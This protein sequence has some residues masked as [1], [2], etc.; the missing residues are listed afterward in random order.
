MIDKSSVF[1]NN[2]STNMSTISPEWN[3]V[4]IRLNDLRTAQVGQMLQKFHHFLD[5]D[6]GNIL[7]GELAYT[8]TILVGP[9]AA[10][11]GL[12][13]KPRSHEVKPVEIARTN[14]EDEIIRLLQISWN[15]S[16]VAV[17][18]SFE[19]NEIT[20]RAGYSQHAMYEAFFEVSEHP[21]Y[22][23]VVFVGLTGFISDGSRIR[24][25]QA[26]F[27]GV[28]ARVDLIPQI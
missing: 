9:P 14:S 1:I 19:G 8:D 25:V 22:I 16:G 28:C 24:G 2:P 20:S 18:K 21:E 7:P 6:R 11:E 10:L 17:V 3:R 15:N 13:V 27:S 5:E 12:R 26:G 23:N 4:E